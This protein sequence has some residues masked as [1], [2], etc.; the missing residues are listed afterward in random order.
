MS[1]RKPQRHFIGDKPAS[2]VRL[3]SR[4]AGRYVPNGPLSLTIKGTVFEDSRGVTY[5]LQRD[6][7]VKRVQVAREERKAA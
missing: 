2:Y 7:S 6:G 4:V 1:N 5:E 3:V